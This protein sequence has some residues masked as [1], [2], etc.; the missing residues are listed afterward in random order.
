MSNPSK[1]KGTTFERSIADYLKD[2]WSPFIDR[3]PLTGGSDK[4]DIA[5]FYIG[6]HA[7]AVECKNE[8]Q[9][10]LAGW[11]KEAQREGVNSGS[12][13]GIVVAKRKGKANPAEQYC[14]LTLEE[15]L[16]CLRA[17]RTEFTGE[18]PA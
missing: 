14:I 5:N 15:F 8:R 3:R 7:L 13:A 12:L 16:R 2:N 11:V 9:Y 1:Q 4:G 10:N 6:P 17:V 18:H